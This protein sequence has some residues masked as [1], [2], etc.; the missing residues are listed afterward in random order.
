[1]EKSII[2]S[3]KE[4]KRSIP[5]CLPPLWARTGHLQTIL[6][7]LLPSEKVTEDGIHINVT[8]EKETERIHSTY[9]KGSSQTVVY[10]FHGLGGSADSAYVQRAAILA[11]KMGHHVFINNHRGCGLGAG[12]AVEPY[13]SGRSEDLSKVIAYG[14]EM[15]PNHKHIA[16]GFSL[17][18]NALL[19]LAA[20]VRGEVQPDFAIA[21][22]GPINLDRA[23]IKL[24]KGLNKIYDKRFTN[25]LERYMKV[26]RPQDVGDFSLV[27]DLRDFDER[28]TAP[29]GGFK[30]RADYYETCSAKQYLPKINIPTVIITAEDDPFIG[31]EDYRE[32][33]YSPTTVVHI[34]KHG[35]HVGY[36]ARDGLGYKRWLDL[37][38][39]K[40]L[41]VI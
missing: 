3:L 17:S 9:L 19:L 28:Y 40:Y 24:G 41:G 39:G 7:Y 29:L 35:G 1:M 12:L 14:R 8:L 22:N 26:N 15:L 34:E 30:N 4:V 11:R 33:Q 6:G 18:A 13:H 31:I 21:V 2:E 16:I 23:S 36:V 37:A 32:A 20:S 5:P 27:K 25:D 10:L 38:I